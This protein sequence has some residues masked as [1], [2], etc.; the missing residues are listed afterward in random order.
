MN[1]LTGKYAVYIF[2]AIGAAFLIVFIKLGIKYFKKIK[3]S[4][5]KVDKLKKALDKGK[6]KI[7]LKPNVVKDVLKEI[8]ES[9]NKKVNP[10]FLFVYDGDNDKM[11]KY[12]NSLSSGEDYKVI[13]VSESLFVML[14]DN[15]VVFSL[16]TSYLQDIK[17]NTL[18][19]LLDKAYKKGLIQL[20]F[21]LLCFGDKEYQNGQ[22]FIISNFIS[23]INIYKK[24]K[25]DI[26][27]AIDINMSD[28]KISSFYEI[29]K[30]NTSI[31]I[32]NNFE[33]DEIKDMI[34]KK[35]EDVHSIL[36]N[37]IISDS[38]FSESVFDAIQVASFIE[39]KLML[40]STFLSGFSELSESTLLDNVVIDFGIHKCNVH[41]NIFESESSIYIKKVKPIHYVTSVVIILSIISTFSFLYEAYHIKRHNEALKKSNV[42]GGL[43]AA[44]LNKA[45]GLYNRWNDIYNSD[46]IFNKITFG[47]L[48]GD[49]S[50]TELNK[51]YANFMTEKIILPE[52]NKAE[53]PLTKLL[54]LSFIAAS[55][56][57]S[58]FNE[59]MNQKALATIVSN[60][61]EEQLYLIY[62]YSGVVWLRKLKFPAPALY[63]NLINDR[64]DDDNT[65]DN[66]LFDNFLNVR[67]EELKKFIWEKV[68]FQ[69]KVCFLKKA[70][71]YLFVDNVYYSKSVL[72][73][74]NFFK[75]KLP[76][77]KHGCGS[78]L[79]LK[80]LDII[81]GSDVPEKLSFESEV[82][83][84][85][86]YVSEIDN[87]FLK[88]KKYAEQKEQWKKVLLNAEL[89]SIL[90][91]ILG[92]NK[93]HIDLLYLKD[94]YEYTFNTLF[95]RDVIVISL[96]YVKDVI[97]NVIN[98]MLKDYDEL[99]AVFKSYN[100]DYHA[101]DQLKNDSLSEY[102]NEYIASLEKILNNSLPET[103]SSE[104]LKMYLVDITSE[105]TPFDNNID[106]ISENTTFD[107]SDVLPKQ[108][109]VI[110]DTFSGFNNLI[111]SKEYTQYKGILMEVHRNLL[112]GTNDDY[113]KT[114]QQ[115]TSTG[116]DSIIGQLD[117]L[118]NSLGN[119]NLSIYNVFKVPLKII[120]KTLAD[121]LIAYINQQWRLQITP[122]IML[123]ESQFPFNL[124]AKQAIDFEVLN[125]MVGIQGEVFNQ[126]KTLLQPLTSFNEAVS[127]WKV[128]TLLTSEQQ[129]TLQPYIATLNKYSTLQA[130]LWDEKGKAKEMTFNVKP[131]AFKNVTLDGKNKMVLTFMHGGGKSQSL[132]LNTNSD[133]VTPLDYPW[134]LAPT[135]SVGWLNTDNNSFEKS[136]QGDWAFFRMLVDAKCSRRW[137]CTWNIKGNNAKSPPYQ[138]SFSIQSNI[139]KLVKREKKE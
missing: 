113:V 32:G 60:L 95:S 1:L 62:K 103:V 42:F 84:I 85:K 31:I 5:K 118:M 102:A 135:V 22:F 30:Q 17:M 6:G 77:T 51:S 133:A 80:L 83:L 122:K 134:Q 53:D 66:I 45:D 109:N 7:K 57:P 117:T 56:S 128:S 131:Q 107:K 11:I 63:G 25:F 48:Y 52:I 43:K 21:L 129:T 79:L 8:K 89:N 4:K 12:I 119:V 111:Q 14:S 76:K 87:F 74:I 40:L 59:L 24:I 116:K 127:K 136:Y 50:W 98:P 96:A 110:A 19:S 47:L 34:N 104:N 9:S 97:I 36:R 99:G 115:L 64:V 15:R 16:S 39:K 130:M 3:K 35:M 28:E 138:V 132:G 55:N 100:I 92:S 49:Y 75:D 67:N 124:S 26:N 137:L 27:I 70:I 68:V 54:F 61:N 81:P 121:Y 125:G 78:E 94:Y 112:S 37:E 120:Q 73:Y 69:R 139:L 20:P 2:S 90:N 123:I 88:E 10:A 91:R 126:M 58:M 101:L 18:N 106:F 86:D 46:L 71:P 65:I 108:L 82:Y 38:S 93:G 13:T 44:D 23:E 72:N 105:N 114:Y 33:T 41:Y 29:V